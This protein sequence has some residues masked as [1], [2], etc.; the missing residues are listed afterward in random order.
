MR[1]DRFRRF[2]FGIAHAAETEMIRSRVQHSLAASSR[3]VA[4]A[5]LVGAKKRPSTMHTLLHSWFIRVETVGGPFR[6]HR[7]LASGRH[8]LIVI[9]TVPIGS[10]LPHI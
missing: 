8:G 4:R 5:V 10:P 7:D 1:F 9:R 6:V 2:Q 3:D